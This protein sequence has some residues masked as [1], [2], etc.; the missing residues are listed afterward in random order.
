MYTLY[1]IIMYD[2]F[3]SSNQSTAKTTSSPAQPVAKISSKP[4]AHKQ[5]V[6]CKGENGMAKIDGDA[7]AKKE[8]P[9]ERASEKQPAAPKQS[10]QIIASKVNTDIF[11]LSN[12]PDLHR[13]FPST[14]L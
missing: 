5:R 4:S 2:H 6:A 12:C 14:V 3:R 11:L 13:V 9:K 7:S 10:R 1:V 8:K